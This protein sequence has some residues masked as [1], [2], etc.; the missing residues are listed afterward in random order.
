[1]RN[2]RLNKNEKKLIRR[3]LIWCYK[4]VKEDL[5]RVDRYFTQLKADDFVLKHLKKG[6]EYKHS[7]S[8][9]AYKDLVDQFQV[10]MKTKEDNVLKKKYING[11]TA[12]LNPDY[13]YTRNRYTAVEEAIKHFL[14]DKELE[15][16][17]D[18]YEKEM[19]R[20]ILEAREHG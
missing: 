12:E 15:E 18:L 5:D 6:K 14:G 17:S 1:M 3:Y 10:Y 2:V 4:T 11:G 7:A 9:K 8:T 19:T 20:R 16:I 13:Q